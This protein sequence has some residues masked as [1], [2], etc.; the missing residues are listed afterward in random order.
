MMNAFRA[1]FHFV[2]SAIGILLDIILLSYHAHLLINGN[3]NQSEIVTDA[4]V[5]STI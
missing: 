5:L 2:A 3:I 4:I 1:W